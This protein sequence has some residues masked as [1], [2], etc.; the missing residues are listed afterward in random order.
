MLSISFESMQTITA[1]L[2]QHSRVLTLSGS[3]L[4]V[5]GTEEGISVGLVSSSNA[6]LSCLAS[7]PA[8]QQRS[9]TVLLPAGED[10]LDSVLVGKG[11]PNL[12]TFSR[13]SLLNTDLLR[14]TTATL[15][16]SPCRISSRR[17]YRLLR[18]IFKE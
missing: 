3:S 4:V 16:A 15:C 1:P 2:V 18:R 12:V 5:N 11:A 6:E 8:T 10:A 9:V 17:A 14:Q 7:V 13:L